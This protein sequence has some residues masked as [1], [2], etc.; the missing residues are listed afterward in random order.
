MAN[1]DRVQSSA[2]I[3]LK[4][5]W[6]GVK[7]VATYIPNKIKSLI[8]NRRSEGCGSDTQPLH[9]VEEEKITV[10]HPV[11]P[12]R[13]EEL[14]LVKQLGYGSFGRVDLVRFQN[15]MFSS[16]FALKTISLRNK[17]GNERMQI[18]I[19][20][21][22]NAMLMC[23][24]SRFIIKLHT[25]Y[26]HNDFVYFLMDVCIGYD[27]LDL[28]LGHG[29][30]NE[31][32]GKF[33]T[34]CL[35]EAVGYIH[36]LGLV[37]RDIKLDNLLVD[38]RTGYL[39][40]TD[41]GMAKLVPKGFKTNTFCGSQQYMAPEFFTAVGDPPHDR[42]VDLWAIGVTLFAM[43]GGLFPF[44]VN[45]DGKMSDEIMFGID[46]V[47]FPTEIKKLCRSLIKELC[48]QEPDLRL[49]YCGS[50][51]DTI[52]KHQWFEGLHWNSLRQGTLQAPKIVETINN[53]SSPITNDATTEDKFLGWDEVFIKI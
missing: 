49:G 51:D 47:I 11:L 22:K 41:F 30:L 23:C 45:E 46:Y 19:N 36:S 3:K 10:L 25:T 4:G 14:Q 8:D 42:A 39:K 13:L 35:V 16:L 37:H 43:L 6:N 21:E 15:D 26:Q 38:S 20:R 1:N 17:K 27:M 33:Y 2:S 50:I 5:F 28:L 7:H 53:N 31:W 48:R 24:N 29:I 9:Q 40:L 52:K 34:A 18:L 32:E 12:D 44:Q